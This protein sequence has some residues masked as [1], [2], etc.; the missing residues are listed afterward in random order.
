MIRALNLGRPARYNPGANPSLGLSVNRG[1]MYGHFNE[2]DK[3]S[4]VGH[5]LL[6][7]AG[8]LAILGITA[9]EA[10]KAYRMQRWPAAACDIVASH[11]NIVPGANVERPYVF[12]V[13][14]RFPWQG[15]MCVS[16]TYRRDYHGS[17]EISEADRLARAFPAAIRTV[18]F[19][20]PDDPTQ[21]VLERSAQW[22][23]VACGAAAGIVVFGFGI[24]LL[25][26]GQPNTARGRKGKKAFEFIGGLFL[27]TMGLAGLVFFFG[28]GMARNFAARTWIITP[29]RILHSEV[30]SHLTSGQHHIW[31]HR[32]DIVFAYRVGGQNY[33]SSRFNFTELSTP[34][35]YGKRRVVR[36]YPPRL[37]TTCYVNPADPTEA[38]LNRSWRLANWFALWPLVMVVLGLGLALAA[39][40]FVPSIDSYF[41]ARLSR[42]SRLGQAAAAVAAGFATQL[43]LVLSGDLASDW[44]AGV[45][46]WE[47]SLWV[48]GSGLVM[49]AAMTIFVRVALRPR[50][51]RRRLREPV[52]A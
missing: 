42:Q 33:R 18:C 11:V 26:M 22:H 6:I 39:T 48:L 21:A 9:Y 1:E 29:C 47:E 31:V 8:G 35:Y 41:R 15:R 3:A 24:V 16:Q 25:T 28:T 13:L 43:F 36:Q 4:R 2:N 50:T 20:D 17:D 52:K 51:G 49:A 34:W 32:P 23:W 46:D 5:G 12:H 10:H 38:V 37:A 40:G 45:A 30:R 27:A 7:A 19:V 44:R 14:Y